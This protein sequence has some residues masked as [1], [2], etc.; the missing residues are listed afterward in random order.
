[1]AQLGLD[2][3]LILADPAEAAAMAQGAVGVLSQS[4]NTPDELANNLKPRLR[5][6]DRVLCK[7]SRAV[8]L[9]RVV[10]ALR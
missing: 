4:F 6:G 7:A 1:V 9:E 5:A 2:E 3:L 8:A 10:Q